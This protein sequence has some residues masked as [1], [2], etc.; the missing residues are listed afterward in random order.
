MIELTFSLMEESKFGSEVSSE[1]LIDQKTKD[2]PAS[3]PLALRKD[4]D[5]DEHEVMG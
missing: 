1:S 4:G 3:Q 5:D 2:P